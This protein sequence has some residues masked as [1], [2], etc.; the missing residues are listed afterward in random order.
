MKASARIIL[1]ALVA[2]LAGC[3]TVRSTVVTFTP[4]PTE[5]SSETPSEEAP[6][7][8]AP[9]D[10]TPVAVAP[11]DDSLPPGQPTATFV[12]FPTVEATATEVAAAATAMPSP[13]DVAPP[14]TSEGPPGAPELPPPPVATMTAGPIIG[15]NYT[16]AVTS[17]P[18]PTSSPIPSLT[19]T[20]GP[21][22]T[23]LPTLRSELLGVQ[24]HP[25][26]E[27]EALIPLLDRAKSEL[28]VRWIKYQVEWELL[29]PQPGQRGVQFQI[30]ERFIQHAHNRDLR[31]LIS[32]VAAPDWTRSPVTMAEYPDDP[33]PEEGPPDDYQ[34]YAD[35]IRYMSEHFVNRVN[36]IEVWNEPN[37]RRE[38]FNK[39]LGGAEYM[40][41]FDATYR[42][43][44][45][46]SNPDIILVTAAPA[47]TGVNDHVTA[48]DDRAFLTEMYRAGLAN[49]DANVAV[50]VHPYGWGNPPGATCATDCNPGAERGW[51]DQRFFFFRDT[52]DD[53]RAIMTQF[54]DSNRQMW[55]TEV[56][57]PT[58]DGFG[59]EPDA[60]IGFF[61]YVTEQDQAHYLIEALSYMQSQAYMGPAFIWNMNWAIFAGRDGIQPLEQEAGY[62][63]LRPDGS[64]RPAYEL[65]RRAPKR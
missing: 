34:T 25:F 6:P 48:V 30:L 7:E 41:L 37:L 60:A 43:V 56:G 55:A 2:L 3:V 61:K 54:G 8:E 31:V 15:P 28:G 45:S 47:P 32:V 1:M 50:G 42:A 51:D 44:R 38:W 5:A 40:R 53:Y 35:F 29:E 22:P 12:M 19:A 64:A 18:P 52:L 4:E 46:G 21:S 24:I 13:A 26:I 23:P 20:P 10:R 63:I 11:T 14:P 27:E 16:P 39:P 58:F 57:W 49:Y 62:A 17:T 9:P 36:A 33:Y 65:L 59:V